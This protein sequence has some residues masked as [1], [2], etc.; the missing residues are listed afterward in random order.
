FRSSGAD[1]GTESAAGAARINLHAGPDVNAS[2]PVGI[3]ARNLA[4]KTCKSEPCSRLKPK[5]SVI[6]DPAHRRKV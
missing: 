2:N 3:F 1:P 4:D 6:G 5:P